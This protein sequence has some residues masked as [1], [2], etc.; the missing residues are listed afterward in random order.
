MTFWSGVVE[1]P[2]SQFGK[3]TIKT[4]NPR[5]VRKNVGEDY[6]GCLVVYVRNSAALN[7][8]IGGWCEG[9]AAATQGFSAG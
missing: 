8:Q 9:V 2:A 5:T 7:L 4:H 6:H 1:A 3:T